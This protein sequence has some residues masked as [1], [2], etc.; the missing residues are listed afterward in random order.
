MKL[1]R[2]PTETTVTHADWNFDALAGAGV[3]RSTLQDMPKFLAANI[4]SAS[5]ARDVPWRD[6]FW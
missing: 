6:R 1:I 2:L 3:L 4:D 5:S